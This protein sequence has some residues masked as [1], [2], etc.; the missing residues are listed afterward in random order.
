MG[1]VARKN[2]RLFRKLCG[3]ETLKN[4]VIATN[5]WSDVAV[6]VGEKREHELAESELFFKPALE[7]G[8]HL[9]RHDNTLESARAIV[10]TIVGFPAAA[11]QIQVETVD[12]RK[13]LAQT[14]AGQDL[15][16]ELARLAEAHKEELA[17]L[18][19][20]MAELLSA[21]DAQ[22]K[23]EID[24]LNDALRDVQ[25][26]L[27]KVETEARALREEHEASRAAHEVAMRRMTEEM[28]AREAELRA[29]QA[30]ARLQE[31]KVEELEA[32]LREAERKAVEE[33][34]HRVRADQ[35]LM[36]TNAAYQ[37]ELERMRRSF[38]EQLEASRQEALKREEAQRETLRR[39]AA[40]REATLRREAEEREAVQRVAAQRE[41]EQREAA[42]REA[43][44]KWEIPKPQPA[45]TPTLPRPAAQSRAQ[46]RWT[47]AYTATTQRRGLFGALSLALDQL[48]GS[49]SA[50]R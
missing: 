4:V 34:S 33:E 24:E 1:G 43:A 26:Q 5:M 37:E 20:E 42:K 39:E 27:D 23:T 29:L 50:S 35:D 40:Q 25:G 11:L 47:Y 21:K 48:F 8:A 19:G 32:A 12:E 2:F 16:A 36:T 3:D 7:K 22:H 38:E 45:R 28:D 14:D 13:A 18:R 6:E 49:T 17:G 31:G 46:E 9:A 10:R 30:S 41:A 44:A 15:A